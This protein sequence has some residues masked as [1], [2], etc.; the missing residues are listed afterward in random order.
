MN[1]N[2]KSFR[3]C[4]TVFPYIRLNTKLIYSLQMI[5]FSGVDVEVSYEAGK[6]ISVFV[7]TVDLD[8]SVVVT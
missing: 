3:S 1:P 2:I 4:L 8:L 7:G 5:I 6:N